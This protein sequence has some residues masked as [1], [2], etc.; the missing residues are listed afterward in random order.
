MSSE[1]TR[2]G[3]L[4]CPAPSSRGCWQV[5]VEL[6]L[7]GPRPPGPTAQWPSSGAPSLGPDEISET[8]VPRWDAVGAWLGV[9]GLPREPTRVW[10]PHP[11]ASYLLD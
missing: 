4:H 5:R 11:R 6:P 3:P 10:G 8:A 9:E 2:V 1:D 7:Q